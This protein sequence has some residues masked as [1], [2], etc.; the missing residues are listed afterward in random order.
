MTGDSTMN[1]AAV[2]LMGL[3]KD[4]GGQCFNQ[5]YYGSSHLLIFQ[6]QADFTWHNWILKHKEKILPDIVVLTVGAHAHDLGDMGMIWGQLEKDFLMFREKFF[7][8]NMTYIWKTQ[9]PGHTGCLNY[10][11]PIT[12]VNNA[13]RQGKQFHEDVYD[14]YL[15]PSFDALS[16]NQSLV[17]GVKI[18]DM[19]P[20]YERPDAHPASAAAPNSTIKNDCL[21][22]CIPGPI[23]LFATLFLQ[24]LATGEV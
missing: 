18:L 23:D 13:Y 8:H 7:W 15:H 6:N 10:S 21:H 14:W 9:Q 5:I 16:I 19:S 4:H 11:K 24:M 17:N 3:I 20:L 22:Y 2:T 12:T 1:Q